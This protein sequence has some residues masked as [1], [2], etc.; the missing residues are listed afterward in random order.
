MIT[1][2]GSLR[3]QSLF[4]AVLVTSALL[5][6]QLP[7]PSAK[8]QEVSVMEDVPFSEEHD[9]RMD[10]YM[11]SGEGPFPGVMVIHGG[12]WFRGGKSLFAEEAQYLAERGFVA[13]AITYRL[14]PENPFPAAL[15][16]VQASVEFVREH[17]EEFNLDPDRVGA[18][19]GSAGGH[20][21][22]MLATVGEGARNEGS[23]VA[24]AVSWSGPMDLEATFQL[25]RNPQKVAERMSDFLD[26]DLVNSLD[27]CQDV[28]QEASPISQVDPT[29]APL[30]LTNAEREPIPLQQAVSM[31]EALAEAGVEHQ[32]VEILG[33]HCHSRSCENLRPSALAGATVLEASVQWLEQWLQGQPGPTIE[34]PSPGPGSAANPPGDTKEDG[35]RLPVGI[36]VIAGVGVV[37]VVLLVALAAARRRRL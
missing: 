36:L 18:L 1:S 24:A 19:G 33:Q 11:P 16:D 21:A 34:S 5:L 37:L 10:V 27:E 8:A 32:L 23:R 6:T 12:G 3:P 13:F 30:F 28:L 35:E 7:T 26:C 22:A 29:D 15:D 17:S 20:L 31:A 9:L 25:S 14:A 2:K 4:R